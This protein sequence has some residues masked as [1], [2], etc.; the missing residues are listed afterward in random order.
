MATLC[1]L[2]KNT[3]SRHPSPLLTQNINRPCKNLQPSTQRKALV[4][5]GRHTHSL[6][7]YQE[8]NANCGRCRRRIQLPIRTHYWSVR[9]TWPLTSTGSV[10][11][12]VSWAYSSFPV[13]DT[14]RFICIRSLWTMRGGIN[15]DRYACTR[16]CVHACTQDSAGC[17]VM[18]SGYIRMMA[19][20]WAMQNTA[21]PRAIVCD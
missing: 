17:R 13:P 7:D 20:T 1:E 9:N 18:P 12:S 5:V 3:R 19:G 21:R 16:A 11:R 15:D 14:R 4:Y 10:Q 8:G 6:Q 2:P